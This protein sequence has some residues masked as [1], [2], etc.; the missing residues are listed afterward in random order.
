M[1]GHRSSRRREYG[2]RQKDVRG[3]RVEPPA[4]LDAPSLW[5]R[6]RA[7]GDTSTQ[8]SAM[9]SS[10]FADQSPA[11]VDQSPTGDRAAGSQGR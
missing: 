5:V 4:N 6:G 1:S 11:F 2:R 9:A 8:S 7:W 3:R 10:R